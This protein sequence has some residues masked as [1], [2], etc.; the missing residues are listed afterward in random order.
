MLRRVGVGAGQADAPVRALGDRGPH[1][2]AGQPPA[3]VDPLGAGAQRGQV[4]AGARLGEQ[5]A[6]DQLAPQRR[7][8]EPL[9]LRVVAVLEDRRQRPAGDHDVGPGDAGPGQLLVDDD[10]GDGVGAEAVRRRPVRRQVAGLDQRGPPLLARAAPRSRAA[11]ARTSG[12]TAVVAALEVDLDL[13]AYAVDG[14]RGQPQGGRVGVADQPAQRQRAAQVEVRVV[15]V[16]EADAAEHLDA[17]LGHGHRAVEA[18]HLGDVGG[19]GPLVVVA[20]RPAAATSHAAA[21]TASAVSSISAHRCLT[22]WKAPIF[23]PNCSRTLAYSTAVS[24]H[25]RATPAASA[26]ARVTVVRRTSSRRLGG[27]RRARAPYR[28]LRS[29]PSCRRRVARARPARRRPARASRPA[30]SPAR[31]GRVHHGHRRAVADL[32]ARRHQRRRPRS[33]AAAPAPARARTPRARPPGRGPSRR[34]R[35]TPRAAPMVATPISTQAF[36][37]S[38]NVASASESDVAGQPR[39]RPARPPTRAG[40]ARARRAPRRSRSTCDSLRP[41]CE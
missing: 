12:R 16:G 14:A 20:R 41:C 15:L 5:L 29:M 27:R 31:P 21:V 26:A 36:Q 33:T 18:G 6:P 23:W 22:A 11:R 35:R 10:L 7:R 8:H 28:R 37:A 40:C 19:V 30:R 13:A 24:R 34:P 9:A 32:G 39:A 1:L 17:G 2:L 4:G 38:A 3:T 25:Q